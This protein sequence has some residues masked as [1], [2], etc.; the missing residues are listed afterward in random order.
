MITRKDIIIYVDM[1]DTLC[2]FLGEYRKR[3]LEND[4]L[5]YPQSIHGFFT[6]LSPLE[7]AIESYK[8]LEKHFDVRILTA[9]SVMNPSCYTEKRLWVEQHLGMDACHKMIICPDKSLLKGEFLID[10]SITK[11]Q[12]EFEG[13]FLRF[14]T[15]NITWKSIISYFDKLSTFDLFLIKLR[16]WLRR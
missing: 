3:K 12:L 4:T 9:P 2:D 1:D 10:D 13:E 6:N 16:K 14:G 15:D 5:T 11:G 8:L 7:D